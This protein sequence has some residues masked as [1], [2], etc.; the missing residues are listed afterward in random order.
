MKISQLMNKKYLTDITFLRWLRIAQGC[1]SFMT[2]K[3]KREIFENRINMVQLAVGS[4]KNRRE[5]L[6]K[7]T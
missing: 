4:K 6:T 1:T 3:Q 5:P 7:S 2:Y